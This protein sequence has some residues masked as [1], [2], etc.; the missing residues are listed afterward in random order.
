MN[1]KEN[2]IEAA[3]KGE[4]P[5]VIIRMK[6]GFAVMGDTQF[7]PGYCVLLGYPTVNSLNHI[8]IEKRAEFLVDMSILGDALM[9]VCKP[10]RINYEIL[11]NTDAFLHAHV[12]PRYLWEDENRRKFPVFQYPKENWSKE[13][14]QFNIEKHGLLKS[15]LAAK[16]EELML[17]NYK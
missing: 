12:F 14:Y 9:D 17:R 5:T 6:S 13:E 1:W 4:N 11:G 2:R 3:L 8:S 16:L 10:I 15:Q 7:L